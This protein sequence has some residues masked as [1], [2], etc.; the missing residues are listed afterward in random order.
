MGLVPE[1]GGSV[2]YFRKGCADVMRSLSHEDHAARNVLGVAMFPMVPYADRI[3]RNRFSFEGRTYSFSIN[4]PPER[5]NVHGSGWHLPWT[6]HRLSQ[7][8]IVLRLEHSLL[9][10]HTA[11]ALSSSS[12]C[13]Q[14]LSP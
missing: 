5:Y 8:E 12:Y 4:N 2:A 6:A 3:A 11:T 13:R 10:S 1:I 7:N 9:K 14:M